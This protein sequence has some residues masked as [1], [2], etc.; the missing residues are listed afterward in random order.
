MK[1]T[2]ANKQSAVL[3]LNGKFET[4]NCAEIEYTIGDTDVMLKTGGWYYDP[5][6][7]SEL[8]DFL[9]SVKTHLETK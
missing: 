5:D 2:F 6:D 1:Y 9:T 3:P 4:I 8:I 7:L